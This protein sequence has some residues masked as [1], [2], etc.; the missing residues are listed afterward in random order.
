MRGEGLVTTVSLYHEGWV[1]PAKTNIYP[2]WP[3]LLGYSGR[4]IGL[5]RAAD[6]LPRLFYVVD[7]VLL[8]VL[9]RALSFR[10]GIAHHGTLVGSG[11]RALDGVDLRTGAAILRRDDASVHRGSGV[12][13]GLR[14]V[15]CAGAVRANAESRR[16]GLSG[17]FAGLAF[18]ART[19]MV[20]VAVGCFVA[21][22]WVRVARC[23]QHEWSARR[24]VRRRGR[25]DCAVALLHR[26][27]P[28]RH[29]DAS[30]ARATAA[31]SGLD[32]AAHTQRVDRAAPRQ[33]RG[34][35]RSSNPYSYVQSFGVVAYLVPLAALVALI[36]LVRRRKVSPRPSIVVPRSSS[37]AC[38]S[39]ST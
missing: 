32:G 31:I 24:V 17:L 2:L 10:A 16:G 12:R 18:L 27:H 23:A 9:A 20:G 8:Y 28:R 4:V 5:E 29:A 13:D 14:G 11:R 22:A 30:A 3:L 15:H 25:D 26:L 39:S 34:D 6:L 38:S 36:E 7:L 19:Q 33:S 21:L 1:L 35:V 37:P